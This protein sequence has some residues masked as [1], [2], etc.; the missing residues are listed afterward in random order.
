[1][2]NQK[3][4]KLDVRRKTAMEGPIKRLEDFKEAGKRDPRKAK[5]NT[6]QNK[7]PSKARA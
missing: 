7:E 6:D 1:M 3:N 2:S 5:K 4:N